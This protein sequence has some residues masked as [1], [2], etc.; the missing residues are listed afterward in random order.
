M[1]D[2]HHKDEEVEEDSSDE[3]APEP[4]M[5]FIADRALSAVYFPFPA[6]EA[7][8]VDVD[9][10]V[11]SLRNSLVYLPAST[12]MPSDGVDNSDPPVNHT[13]KDSC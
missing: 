3:E 5:F 13:K 1:W 11:M 10:A 4:E 2:L 8:A 9:A 12:I 6:E 7:V